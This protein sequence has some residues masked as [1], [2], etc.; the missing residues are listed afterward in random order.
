[1]KGVVFAVLALAVLASAEIYFQETF[2][3]DKV[4]DRW[5]H[6]NAKVSEGTAGEMKVSAG[7][8]F[9][10]AEDDKGLQTTQDSKFYMYTCEIP[11][12]FSN[13]DKTLVFQYQLKQEQH[14][15]CGGG[16]LKLLPADSIKSQK[17][18]NA[19]SKYN[20]MFG[21]DICGM[22]T[23]RTHVIF[24]DK[25][26]KNH[27]IK[28][29][30]K[31]ETDD[32]SHLYTL[33]VFPNNTYEVRIDRT[34]VESGSL[35]DDWDMVAPKKIKDPK[36]SKPKDWID[37]PEM[38]D[39]EDK[40]PADWDSIP[41]RIPDPEAK[42]PEDWDDE[43]D[44]DWEAPTIE[45]PEYKGEWHPKRI[46]NPAYKGEWVHPLIDNPDYKPN[47]ELYAYPSF[48]YVAVEIWQ[49]KS[50]SIYDNILL[51]DSLETA[52]E[53]A[54]K[55]ETRK[56]AEMLPV[57]SSTRRSAR[58]L[59]PSGRLR[60]LRRRRRTLRMLL[61]MTIRFVHKVFC[62]LLLLQKNMDWFLECFSG[63][64]TKTQTCSEPKLRTTV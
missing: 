60:R 41:A 3:D 43:T 29:D 14:I 1:M 2:S 15:D 64:T 21:P 28:K 4:M 25:E 32:L 7:K 58:L 34:K 22:S 44:G 11:K 62:C 38:D 63:M 48:K 46:P 8:F 33:I 50:G 27:L 20:I 59:R 17:D 54:A 42:K 9:A 5:V 18:F 57:T 49:V 35:E 45:N 23:R 37:D 26:G 47:P 10:D 13:K 30:V 6:S 12:E 61:T 31:C 40:K 16:Y 51:T 55:W 52:D 24:S 56:T 39:P 53:W 36:Q 19:D